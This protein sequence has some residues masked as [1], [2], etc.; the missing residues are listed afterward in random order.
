MRRVFLL[1]LALAAIAAVSAGAAPTQRI[2]C[3]V[4]ALDFYFWPKGHPAIPALGFPEYPT[5]HLEV[6]TGAAPGRLGQQLAYVSASDFRLVAGCPEKGA[7]ATRWDGGPTKTLRGATNKLHCV[8]PKRVELL[9]DPAAGGVALAVTLGH[10]SRAAAT[11]FF[12][13]QSARLDYDARYC[14][15]VPGL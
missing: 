15:I 5:P 11:A 4:K 12:D 14:K 9:V 1:A 10:S 13:Q 6:Y 2:A 8:F 7:T 3:G